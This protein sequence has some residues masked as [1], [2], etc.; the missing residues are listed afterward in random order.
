MQQRNIFTIRVLIVAQKLLI[1]LK[2]NIEIQYFKIF[3]LHLQYFK[4][5]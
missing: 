5:F 2:Q 4:S 3:A 1:M